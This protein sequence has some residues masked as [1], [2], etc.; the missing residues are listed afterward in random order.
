MTKPPLVLCL[1][2]ASGLSACAQ[3]QPPAPPPPAVPASC[4]AAGAQFAV[5]HMASEALASQAQQRAGAARVRMLPPGTVTTKEYDTGRL[6]LDLDGSGR[7][8]RAYCG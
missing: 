4:N 3:P 1:A 6:N 7:I 8:V 5:G 2:L